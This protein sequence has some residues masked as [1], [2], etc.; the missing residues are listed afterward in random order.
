MV[1]LKC[2][3]YGDDTDEDVNQTQ[4]VKTLAA[5]EKEKE[6][7]L[8]KLYVG[9]WNEQ[10]LH[11]YPKMPHPIMIPNV[12]S[13]FLIHGKKY[14]VEKLTA[15]FSADKGKMLQLLKMDAYRIEE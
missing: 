5:G 13:I 6:E 4:A 8:D 2:G 10:W 12:R 11:W 9:F 7:Y 15:T 3:T 1:F 14:L